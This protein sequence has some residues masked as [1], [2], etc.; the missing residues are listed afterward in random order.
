MMSRLRSLEL[1][2]RL[3]RASLVAFYAAIALLGSGGLHA[4]APRCQSE[5]CAAEPATAH[6]HKGCTHRH[7]GHSHAPTP[8][9]EKQNSPPTHCP[10]GCLICEFA[11]TP[12]VPVALV[13]LLPQHEPAGTVTPVFVLDEPCVVASPF[14]IRGPPAQG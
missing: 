1:A 7:H 2:S 13:H 14:W 3:A 9:E 8:V 10:E 5:C 12:A 6:A 4:I 11:A